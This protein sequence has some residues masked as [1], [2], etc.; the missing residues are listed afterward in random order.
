[1]VYI[2]AGII[3][4]LVFFAVV[5]DN[6]LIGGA[7]GDVYKNSPSVVG[8]FTSILTIFGLLFATAFFNNAALRD[9]KY[10][11][12]QILFS[13]PLNKAG[14]FFGRFLGAW[15]LSTLVMTG[16]YIGMT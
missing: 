5:S 8:N 2:F 13:T 16:I 11:F 14:Y 9:H 1:M 10:N 4:L 6:V 15:L 3:A 7:V 12:S